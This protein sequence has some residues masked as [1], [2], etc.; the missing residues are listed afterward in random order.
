MNWVFRGGLLETKSV[1]NR[2]EQEGKNYS[3]RSWQ[4]VPGAMLPESAGES[5]TSCL[6]AALLEE[7]RQ[8]F[9]VPLSVW[10]WHGH[11]RSCGGDRHSGII[12]WP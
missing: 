5:V 1:G 4:R 9:C 8:G 10:R 2:R 6:A 3:V 12:T 11:A 7:K